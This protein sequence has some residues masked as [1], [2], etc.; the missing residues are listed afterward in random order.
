MESCN[1]TYSCVTYHTG[2]L[3]A[4]RPFA[5]CRRPQQI[6]NLVHGFDFSLSWEERR[7]HI[8]LHHYAC[9]CKNIDMPTV[10]TVQQQLRSPVP[11]S[12]YVLC[13]RRH[14]ADFPSQSKVTQLDVV[15]VTEDVLRL[16]V[17]VKIAIL[18]QVGQT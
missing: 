16:Q 9:E 5:L 4:L 1:L 13:E 18:V 6:N 8:E 15:V 2:H 14:G 3:I 7:H 11:A 10:L 12:G 17:T